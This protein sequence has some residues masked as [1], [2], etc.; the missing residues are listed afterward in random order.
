MASSSHSDLYRQLIVLLRNTEG[1]DYQKRHQSA[2]W[3][4][5]VNRLPL[6][7]DRFLLDPSWQPEH[8]ESAPAIKR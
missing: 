3:F 4:F 2:E 5:R 7:E 6:P 1:W 8:A